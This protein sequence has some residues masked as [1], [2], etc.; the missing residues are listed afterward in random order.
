MTKRS[1]S[2]AAAVQNPAEEAT[3]LASVP[4]NDASLAVPGDDFDFMDAGGT[5]GLSE[6]DSDDMRI[7]VITWNVKGK[8]PKTG[9]MRRVDYFFDTLQETQFPSLRCV[10]LHLH[11]SNNFSRF[12]QDTNETKVHCTSYD[13]KTGRMRTNHPD[14][15][16][17]KEGDER[18][19]EGCVDKNWYKD[20]KGKN[21]RNCDDIYGVFGVH[22]GEDGKIGEGFLMRFKRT[23]LPAFKTHMQ[24]H[25]I[26]RRELPGGKRGNMPLW[27]YPVTMK[28]EASQNGIFATPVIDRGDRLP[29]ETLKLVSEFADQV[30]GF[31]AHVNEAADKAESRHNAGAEEVGGGGATADDF[32]DT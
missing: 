30:R 9:D 6:V 19:C 8:D 7:P 28:L 24:K 26:G 31:G 27:A 15:P 10:F 2:A 13:R 20:A 21:V 12:N 1:A 32:T 4:D 23:S 5:D 17:V 11:K 14:L 29:K 22:L 18:P 3:A 16:Q 25:H